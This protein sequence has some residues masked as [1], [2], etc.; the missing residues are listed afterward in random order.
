MEFKHILIGQ[1]M[2]YKLIYIFRMKNMQRHSMK[3]V[4]TFDYS[5]GTR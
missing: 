5:F 4:G 1:T 2:E 3:D